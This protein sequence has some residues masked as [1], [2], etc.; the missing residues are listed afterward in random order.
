LR[1]RLLVCA[2][3]LLGLLLIELVLLGLGHELRQRRE[4]LIPSG[5]LP[6]GIKVLRVVLRAL[7]DE[8]GI[9]PGL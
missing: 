3:V 1:L 5:T 9:A 6:R 8:A 7:P 2:G 4:T